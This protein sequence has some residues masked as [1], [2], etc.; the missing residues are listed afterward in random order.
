MKW[1]LPQDGERRF[2]KKYAWLPIKKGNTK[3]WLEHYWQEQQYSVRREN[4][5]DLHIYL[6]EHEVTERKAELNRLQQFLK[7]HRSHE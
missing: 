2:V 7:Q 3:I 6:N 5:D 4:W 1:T